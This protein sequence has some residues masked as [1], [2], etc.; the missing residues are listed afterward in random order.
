MH[1]REIRNALCILFIV[2]HRKLAIEITPKVKLFIFFFYVSHALYIRNN[3]L[4]TVL[5]ETLFILVKK[6]H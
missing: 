3:Y 5:N 1:L 6:L 2:L 4:K